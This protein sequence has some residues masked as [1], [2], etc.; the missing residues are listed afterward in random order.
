MSVQIRHG[1]SL[2]SAEYENSG[3]YQ[4]QVERVACRC[5]T[6]RYHLWIDTI[7]SLFLT[8]RTSGRRIVRIDETDIPLALQVTRW[9][10]VFVPLSGLN[11]LNDG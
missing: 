9:D 1:N 7:Y 4:F 8:P 2:V 11:Y 6:V 10:K 5:D 3:W